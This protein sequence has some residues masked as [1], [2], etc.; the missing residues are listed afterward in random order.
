MVVVSIIMGL[1]ITALLDGTVSALRTDTP[2]RPGLIHMLWVVNLL[3]WHV[4]V[5][6]TRWH[7]L[8][9]TEWT[10]FEVLAFLYLP[11]VLFAL[12]KVA[13]PSQ[14]QEVRLTDY[15]LENR[16][17]F[18]GLLA[19]LTVGLALGPGIFFEGG[20][21]PGYGYDPRLTLTGLPVCG[22]LAWTSNRR[23]HVVFAFVYTLGLL[24]WFSPNG[25]GFF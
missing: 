11:V 7:A 15:L 24:A 20:V 3:L 16:V 13:F 23:I 25:G 1:G 19:L 21:V 4:Q 17:A 9:R 22:L 12:A 10:R 2:A 6:L 5:W 8:D 14:G 18:F